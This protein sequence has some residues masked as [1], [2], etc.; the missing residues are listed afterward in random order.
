LIAGLIECRKDPTVFQT[1]G[2]FMGTLLERV[3]RDYKED[4]IVLISAANALAHAL[5]RN[6]IA[7]KKDMLRR[8]NELIV[9]STP[10]LPEIHSIHIARCLRAARV[11]VKD[12]S[13]GR[14]DL[15]KVLI[16]EAGRPL[17]LASYSATDLSELIHS[18]YQLREVDL[19]LLS[20]FHNQLIHELVSREPFLRIKNLINKKDPQSLSMIGVS[21]ILFASRQSPNC[22]RLTSLFSRLLGSK[23]VTE[24]MAIE[25]STTFHLVSILDSILRNGCATSVHH[26][27]IR[28]WKAVK[29]I[30]PVIVSKRNSG[31]IPLNDKDMAHIQ[32]ALELARN[33]F[34]DKTI[35][36]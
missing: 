8:V 3:Y 1:H 20:S 18:A 27:G 6:L 17:R 32:A 28:S 22:E 14:R 12:Q 21:N 11:L 31:K 15:I 19:E 9:S 2:A 33:S 10:L 4:A 29:R 35:E 25:G 24:T 34:Q 5:S 36:I 30:V 13:G 23:T 7:E 26:S 16:E